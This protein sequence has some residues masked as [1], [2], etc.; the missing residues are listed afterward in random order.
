ML[1]QVRHLFRCER[2]L[3]EP[4]V[5]D[6]PGIGL[7]EGGASKAQ[8]SLRPDRPGQPV[9]QHLDL[10]ELPVDVDPQARRF[11]RPVVGDRDVMPV[12]V[13]QPFTR[14]DAN[15][16]IRRVGGQRYAQPRRPLLD[17]RERDILGVHFQSATLRRPLDLLEHGHALV[18]AATQPHRQAELI[19]E[20]EA[21]H[22]PEI[23]LGLAVERGATPDPPH[24]EGRLAGNGASV[25][26]SSGD[27]R[28]VSVE[29]VV[30]RQPVTIHR[31]RVAGERVLPQLLQRPDHLVG[32][33]QFARPDLGVERLEL[34][35]LFGGGKREERNGIPR[36]T[37]EADLRHVVEERVELVELLVT[38]GVE[39]VRMTPR[40][41]HRHAHERCRGGFDAID[42][43]FDLV[44]V[45]DGAPLEV[46]HVVAVEA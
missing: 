21:R 36:P 40:T 17:A 1:C 5:V 22:A 44:F 45:G 24:V 29:L 46:D 3:V 10:G 30:R 13:R 27:V 37:V 35:L 7:S 18:P 42:D 32:Q 34:R 4:E 8:G 12:A 25:L 19:P 14:A 38:N 11:A 28:E 20:V 26:V 31:C 15:R 9:V 33:R 23:H 2:P 6:L 16:V 43:V 39:L 41:P